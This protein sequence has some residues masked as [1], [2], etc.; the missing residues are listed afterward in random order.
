MD[1]VFGAAHDATGEA[2]HGDRER[3]APHVDEERTTAQLLRRGRHHNPIRTLP[4]LDIA[5]DDDGVENGLEL[6]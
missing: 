4:S 1:R 6:R 2:D 5:I 3:P